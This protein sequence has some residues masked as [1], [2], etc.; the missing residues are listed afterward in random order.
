MAAL[1]QGVL[2]SLARRVGLAEAGR[3]TTSART[4]RLIAASAAGST[5]GAGTAMI[6]RSTAS[7]SASA[8]EKAGMDWTTAAVRLTGYTGPV[9][10]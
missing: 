9:K 1:Q 8:V 4:P 3:S 7:G 2:P 5:S 6:A 10:P